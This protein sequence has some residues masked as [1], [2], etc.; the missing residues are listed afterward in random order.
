MRTAQLEEARLP[1]AYCLLFS[2][3]FWELPEPP[4]RYKS[5]LRCAGISKDGNQ[6][7]VITYPGRAFSLTLPGA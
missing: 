5:V 6:T 1:T 3:E 4:N 7:V 2:E